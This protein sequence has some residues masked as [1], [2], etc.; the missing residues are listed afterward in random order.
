MRQKN[1]L[2]PTLLTLNPLKKKTSY[3]NLVLKI[4]KAEPDAQIL[5]IR[6]IPEAV[7]DLHATLL[8]LFLRI[9]T[10]NTYKTPR[11]RQSSQGPQSPKKQMALHVTS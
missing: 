7:T 9:I 6:G 4:L 5:R 10:S 3:C 2:K 11:V 1:A 8:A